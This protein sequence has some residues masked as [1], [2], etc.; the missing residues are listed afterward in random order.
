[1]TTYQ[2]NAREVFKEKSFVHMYGQRDP[3]RQRELVFGS[4]KTKTKGR[5]NHEK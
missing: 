5:D 1:M 3:T 4:K 2:N